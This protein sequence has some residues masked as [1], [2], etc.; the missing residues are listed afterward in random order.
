MEKLYKQPL[1]SRYLELFQ[2]NENSLI[3]TA[4][5]SKKSYHKITSIVMF[6]DD[7]LR[8]IN[9]D[10]STMVNTY[11]GKIID[12]PAIVTLI[13]V[14]H[15][16]TKNAVIK[17]VHDL[18]NVSTNAELTSRLSKIDTMFDDEIFELNEY[19]YNNIVWEITSDIIGKIS[20]YPYSTITDIYISSY[21]N[22]NEI[23][24]SVLQD[25]K[26]IIVE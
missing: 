9:D 19:T 13:K 23:P 10:L 3:Q 2:I 1:N 14:E 12:N 16:V 24:S 21:D 25:I 18:L 11:H 7:I 20:S 17:L 5:L 6:F 26:N 15:E 22:I 4:M 8:E